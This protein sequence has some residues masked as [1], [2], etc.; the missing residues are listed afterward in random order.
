MLTG[1]QLSR[2]L[3]P[4]LRAAEISPT[5]YNVLRILRGSPEGL[6]CGEIGE[7]MITRDPDITRLLARLEK[8]GLIS[9]GRGR[10]IDAWYLPGLRTPDRSCWPGSMPRCWK[11]IACC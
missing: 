8:R 3:E 11:H 10:K 1:D 2:R 4:V 9:R 7:H 6:T 5:Q